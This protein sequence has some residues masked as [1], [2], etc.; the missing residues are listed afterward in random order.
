MLLDECTASLDQNLTT[1]VVNA[2]RDNY[3]GKMVIIVAHQCI[4]GIFDREII[5]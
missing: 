2:I 4:T 3:E 1:Q 5:V